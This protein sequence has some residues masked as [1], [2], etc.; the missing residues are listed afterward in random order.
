MKKK[1]KKELFLD[2]RFR[3]INLTFVKDQIIILLIE[4][5]QQS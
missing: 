3:R 2:W 5:K 4:I 1:K